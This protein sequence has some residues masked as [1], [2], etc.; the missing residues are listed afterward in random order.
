[1]TCQFLLIS[2]FFN[3]ERKV[4]SEEVV[5]VFIQRCKEVN[6]LINAIVEER[7]DD[8]IE[9]AKEV[10]NMLKNEDLNIADLEKTKPL[11]GVPFTTK[12]SNEAK[13]TTFK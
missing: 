8:A 7:Y 2:F 6:G 10:D 5:K 11:L 1:V 3:R 9:E 4:S 12:E 13:G